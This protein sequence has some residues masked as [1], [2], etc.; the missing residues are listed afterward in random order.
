MSILTWPDAVRPA[1]IAWHLRPNTS[2]FVSPLTGT[3]QTIELPG[4]AWV[5]EITLDFVTEAKW[6]A[7]TAFLA[8]LRGQAGRAYVPPFHVGTGSSCAR[9]ATGSGLTCDSS[10]VTADSAAYSADDVTYASLGTPRV[11]GG[12]QSGATLVTDG[13]APGA[14]VFAAG[15]FFH[16][17]TAFDARS[18]HMVTESV[19]ADG[20]GIAVLPI[21]PPIRTAP[22]DNTRLEIDAPSCIMAIVEAMSG[23]PNFRPGPFASVSV[24]LREVF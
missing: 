17:D 19:I 7:W 8:R 6:R 1:T 4:A 11:A 3:V 2:A 15:D 22:A 20:D 18:L 12:S 24:S 9:S 13:W 14:D 10:A 21:E 16:Y 23:A 5:A